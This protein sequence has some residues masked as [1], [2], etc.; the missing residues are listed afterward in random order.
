M[1]D[2]K[3]CKFYEDC[4]FRDNYGICSRFCLKYTHRDVVRVVR[5]N[6]CRKSADGTCGYK[7]K[8]VPGKDY[9]G[10]GERKNK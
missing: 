2:R 1:A 7:F 5:C 8:H 9:C 10:D 6:D 3:D 4:E